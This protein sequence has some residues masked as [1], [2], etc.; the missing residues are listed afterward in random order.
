MVNKELADIFKRPSLWIA[1]A[2]TIVLQIA[3]PSDAI[4]VI[5][6]FMVY[7]IFLYGIEYILGTAKK[8][9]KKRANDGSG[10]TEQ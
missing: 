2:L 6:N 4:Q 9:L 3:V 1:L 5:V 7:F 10:D 8:M